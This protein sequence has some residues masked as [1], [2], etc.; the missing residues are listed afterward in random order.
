MATQVSHINGDAG[1]GQ[2]ESIWSQQTRERVQ[3]FAKLKGEVKK[4]RSAL[5]ATVQAGI[6]G[7]IDD[8]F[9]K[10]ALEAAIKYAN[11]E[12]SERENFDLTYLYCRDALG[13]PVQ[14]DLF[15]AALQE[16][17]KVTRTNRGKD[18]DSE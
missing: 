4:K 10:E 14:D 15:A 2:T 8:G 18:T 16:R 13:H 6:T 12:E 9:N 11:T 1:E 5:N 3:E 17:V 7:L